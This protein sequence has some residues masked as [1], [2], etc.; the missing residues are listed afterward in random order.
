M[1]LP[2]SAAGVTDELGELLSAALA[3]PP[4][5]FVGHSLGGLYARHY[6]ARFPDQVCGLVLIDP[7]HEDY[8]AYMP[9]E[10]TGASGDWDPSEFIPDEPSEEF[11]SFYRN[12]FSAEAKDLPEAVA[13]PLIEAH[14]SVAWLRNGAMEGA[15]LTD[16]YDEM[17][18]VGPMPPVPVVI[19]CSTGIDDFRRAVSLGQSEELLAAEVGGRLRLYGTVAAGLAQAEVREVADVGHVTLHLRRPDLVD[20]A[21]RDVINRT[22]A[23][24]R[25]G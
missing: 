25:A 3:I 20:Q 15:N 23:A 10:L 8:D 13:A 24:E 16:L 19:L 21:V 1:K 18:Q 2:R 17:R 12:L 11:L 14:L 5:V 9:P 4:F 6:A 7:A 22:I